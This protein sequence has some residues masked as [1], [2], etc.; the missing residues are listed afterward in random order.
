MPVKMFITIDT[1]EDAWDKYS[2]THNPVNNI[3]CLPRLQDIFDRYG[4][5]P[6][7]L[8]N[9]PVVKNKKANNILHNIFDKGRCEIGTHCHPWN[10]P[11]FEEEININNS[12]ICNLPGELIF[13]KIETLHEAIVDSFKIKPVCFRAG[14]WGF[15]PK[16]ARSIQK[17]GYLVD[18]SITPF[19]NWADYMGPD[20]MQASSFSYRF[21]PNDVLREKAGG[22]LLEVPP[23][24]GFFQKN[25]RLCRS[26]KKMTSKALPVAL[27]FPG[28]LNRAGILNFRWLSPE[29]SSGS[30]MIRLSKNFIRIGHRFL[31]MSFHSSSLLPG[32]TPF[33]R[34]QKQLDQFLNRIKMV[35]DFASDQNITFSPLH[36]AVE[37]IK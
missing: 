33:V 28:V 34:N 27:H 32:K 8:V 35:L 36:E 24:T 4:A 21:A 6:T 26:L 7:Y 5:V 3:A 1:E 10:T 18:T 31:N 16:V 23:T 12:M 11:P 19:I 13:K 17:L 22:A 14:R 25:F 2:T 37:E 15:N 29:M 9:W 20:F 30:D